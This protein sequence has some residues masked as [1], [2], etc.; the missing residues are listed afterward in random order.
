MYAGGVSGAYFSLRFVL[1]HI[2]YL[3]PCRLAR[4]LCAHTRCDPCV[5]ASEAMLLWTN[6]IVILQV[7]MR[8]LAPELTDDFAYVRMHC[9][10]NEPNREETDE[11]KSAA[12]P[13][14]TNVW[15]LVYI[16][17]AKAHKMQR[18]NDCCCLCADKIK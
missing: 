5:R 9:N 1:F 11:N 17:Y 8:I 15:L 3:W 18:T 16:L 10:K 4:C 13:S 7:L 14:C 2:L 6:C 12:A